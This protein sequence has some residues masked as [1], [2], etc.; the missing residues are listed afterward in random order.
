MTATSRSF[1]PLSAEDAYAIVLR[2]QDGDQA[3]FADLY[4]TYLHTVFRFVYVKVGNRQLAEDITQ[5]TFVRASRRVAAFTWQG[6]NV[7]AWLITIARNLTVDHFKSHRYRYELLSEDPYSGSRDP[8]SELGNPETETEACVQNKALMTALEQL[9]E[10][11]REV[12]TLRFLKEKTV[13]ETALIMRK[14]E[15]AIKALQYR[16]T[17]AMAGRLP[18]WAA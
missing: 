7:A 15:G 8:H 4:A 2:I 17:R 11:Q 1:D 5:E 9:N 16:A 13:A 14:H 12:L 10:E 18:E 3:A 6:K